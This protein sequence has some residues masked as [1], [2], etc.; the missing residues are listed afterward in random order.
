MSD[1]G[2]YIV[3]TNRAL[4]RGDY[5]AQLLR[6]TE[7]RPRALV[8]REKDLDAKAYGR[9]AKEVLE[10]CR[11]NEVPCFLHTH[12]KAAK[13]LGCRRIHLSLPT[14]REQAG[15]LSGFSEISVSCHS[16]DDVREAAEA[17]ATQVVLGNIFET[18]CKKGLPGKGLE[19]LKEV[20]ALSPVPVYA[21]GGI[22]PRNM[23]EVLAAGAAGG[24]MMSGFMKMEFARQTS[25]QEPISG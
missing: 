4:C 6:V 5:L 14:L 16:M 17:G 2:K 18:D 11:R 24:C 13:E 12:T 22:S 25:F 10:I 15:S 23:E 19:F 1:Y 21:I 20:C 8:L 3:I 7:L 9:L